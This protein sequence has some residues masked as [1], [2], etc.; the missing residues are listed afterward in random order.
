MLKAI[1]GSKSLERILFFLLVNE[2]CYAYQIQKTLGLAITPVQKALAKLEKEN[3]IASKVRGKARIHFFNKLH[4]LFHELQQLVKKAYHQ[5]SSEEKRT[6]YYLYTTHQQ[7]KKNTDLLLEKLYQQMK[8]VSLVSLI[9]KAK[10]RQESQDRKGK[11]TVLVTAE[12]NRLIFYEQ[13]TW[14]ESEGKYNNHFR[15][16][17]DKARGMLKLEHLRYG[18]N[19]PVFLFDLIPQNAKTL[20]SQHPHLC[21]N[22]TYFGQL[23]FHQLFIHLRIR[24]IGP[25]KD[26]NIEYIYT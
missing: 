15:W 3:I 18:N 7:S 4:P 2:E 23:E 16:T 13:G 1:F 26:E 5:L 12:E 24:T 17:W 11:G 6:Y 22:D 9:A 25:Q 19:F 8:Q 21:G 10:H 14:V 20:R